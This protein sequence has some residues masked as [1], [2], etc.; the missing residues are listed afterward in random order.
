MKY[1]LLFSAILAQFE[2][3][4]LIRVCLGYPTTQNVCHW[5]F[6]TYKHALNILQLILIGT[7]LSYLS[8]A[9]GVGH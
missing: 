4:V 3:C 2:G 1:I 7:V 5:L 9:L 6:S 8:L